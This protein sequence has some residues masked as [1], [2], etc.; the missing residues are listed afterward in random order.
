MLKINAV[1]KKLILYPQ[2]DAVASYG[3]TK[4]TPE[5]LISTDGKFDQI[6]VEMNWNFLMED[7]PLLK[8]PV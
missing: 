3:Y 6:G 1:W 4:Q 8:K 5:T 7:R 2:V